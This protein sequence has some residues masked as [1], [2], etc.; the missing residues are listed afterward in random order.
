MTT[1]LDAGLAWDLVDYCRVTLN[2]TQLKKAF[3][4]LGA[5]DYHNAI[6]FAL[7]AADRA[8]LTFP[9]ELQARLIGWCEFISDPLW[10]SR[11]R[12]LLAVGEPESP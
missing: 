8:G 3:I 10:R 7:I 12:R 6:T 2:K 1:Y 9:A 5:G 4:P 11:V